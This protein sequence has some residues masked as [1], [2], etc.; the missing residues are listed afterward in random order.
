MRAHRPRRLGSFLKAGSAKRR[1][2][3]EP[4]ETRLCLALSVPP[5]SSLPG[6]NHTILL[7]F[8]G[9]V[10]VGTTWNNAYSVPT[11]NSPAYDVDGDPNN[12]NSTEL[13]R[14]QRVFDRVAEDF[15]PFAV[16]VTTVD[17]GPDALRYSGGGDTQ[18]GTRV[19]I[20]DDTFANCGCGG[21]AYIGSFDDSQDEPVFV[22]NTSEKGVSEASS[23][24]VGHAMGLG[25]DG[26]SGGAY[27]YGHGSGDTSWAPLMGASYNQNVTQWSKGEY[28]DANNGQDD[29][30]IITSLTNGNG[31][32]Y[33][34]DDHGNTNVAASSLGVSGSTVGDSGII[35]RTNDVDVF[36]FTTDSGNVTINIDPATLGPNLD[37]RAELY[38]S[39]NALVATSDPANVLDANFNLSLAQGQYYLHVSGVGTGDPL[40]ATPTGYTEYGS[41][42]QYS[43]SGTIVD[44][45]ALPTLSIDDVL[46]NEGDGTVTFTVSL[47]GE[48]GSSISVNFA[49]ANGSATSGGDYGAASGILNFDPG[50]TSKP[51]VVTIVDDAV[52]ENAEDFFVNLSNASAGVIIA[53]A[54]GRATIN[55]NDTNVSIN[56]VTANEGNL[57][58]GKKNAG[59]PNLKDFVFTISL[60][61]AVARTVTVNYATADGTA[62][63]SDNDYQAAS[64]VV[65]FAPG[66]TSK[67]ISVSVVGDNDAEPDEDFFVQLI[68]VQGGS[69]VGG[70][71]TATIVNDD[72]GGGGGGGG[73]KGRNKAPQHDATTEHR[74]AFWMFDGASHDHEGHE[75]GIPV[76][77]DQA[78]SPIAPGLVGGAVEDTS[79]I[80]DEPFSLRDDNSHG[81]IV[82]QKMSPAMSVAPTPTLRG[83]WHQID[84]LI[85]ALDDVSDADDDR[86]G[87]LIDE[88]FSEDLDW[89]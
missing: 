78:L 1:L 73:G 21:H 50:D 22:Y 48:I 8:D 26:T 60:S 71:G 56:D 27:Y 19:V 38:D 79:R 7:D 75:H 37:I 41:L 12:F 87:S 33:R 64:G 20:T 16:N 5:L 74:D 31:F 47:S 86:A 6:A 89:L 34:S 51:I 67:T 81:S 55:D 66:E 40:N 49:S 65:N 43:I 23:H 83:Q 13:T 52:A 28:Y 58:K 30:A 11:I 4:L 35:E 82:R 85:F 70:D 72:S 15:S 57:Q 62:T 29:L 76:E 88:V 69:I 3:F 54:Q 32:G 44:P 2:V 18:W 24:E 25:H 61:N 45:G 68:G 59:T 53:D 17:P 9:H 46:V 36:S 10:T 63:T 39:T 84:S 77:V 42:G 80:A 14:I